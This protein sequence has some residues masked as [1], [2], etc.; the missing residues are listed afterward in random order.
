MK[1]KHTDEQLAWL[2]SHL[3]EYENRAGG[4]VRGDAKKFALEKAVKYIDKWGVPEG[5]KETTM[6]E[7]RFS[8]VRERNLQHLNDLVANI[9]LVQEH[10]SERERGEEEA[11]AHE[12][13]VMIIF[14]SRILAYTHSRSGATFHCVSYRAQ[15]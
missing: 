8:T 1:S 6:K 7:V 5:E 13:C 11:S 2:R 4:N 10:L 3:S 9:H 15:Y 14:I 12:E